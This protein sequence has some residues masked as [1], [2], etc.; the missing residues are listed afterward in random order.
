MTFPAA[1]SEPDSR[2]ALSFFETFPM[3][4]FS[5]DTMVDESIRVWRDLPTDEPEMPADDFK[6]VFRDHPAGVAVITASVGGASVGMTATSV[7]SVSADP[8]I[9]VFS[10]SALSSASGALLAAETV[11]VH[12]IDEGQLALAQLCATSGVDRFAD[13]EAWKRLPSGEPLHRDVRRWIRGRIIG[14]MLVGASTVV[15]VQ[16]IEGSH[17]R[18]DDAAVPRPLVYHDRQWHVLGDQS[19]VA[20]PQSPSGDSAR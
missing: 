14:R 6:A 5:N 12:L 11:V 18:G 20:D 19:R 2:R 10:A 3:T 7:I 16:A 1:G 8:P 17:D 4:A 9:L 15:A 13:H